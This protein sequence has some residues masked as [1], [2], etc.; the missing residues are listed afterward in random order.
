MKSRLLLLLG[1][2][3]ALPGVILASFVGFGGAMKMGAQGITA[4]FVG[5]VAVGGV[6]GMLLLG[7]IDSTDILGTAPT[8]TLVIANG[9]NTDATSDGLLFLS[10][11]DASGDSKASFSFY[12]E[13]DVSADTTEA[14]FDACWIVTINGVRRC[15][16][17]FLAP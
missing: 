2:L 9:T 15:V 17:T 5:I 11:R 7:D 12:Q 16:M 10:A 1:L 8:N 3:V 14:G 6:G 4:A 13:Q